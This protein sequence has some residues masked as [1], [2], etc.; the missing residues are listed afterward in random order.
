[1]W[2]NDNGACCNGAPVDGVT[3][4]LTA[5]VDIGGS[6]AVDLLSNTDW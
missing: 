2:S 3:F 5:D 4:V 6:V 1:V